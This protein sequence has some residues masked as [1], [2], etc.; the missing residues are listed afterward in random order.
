MRCSCSFS[1]WWRRSLASYILSPSSPRCLRVVCWNMFERD[2][3]A[4]LLRAS[5]GDAAV[6]L[7]TFGITLFRG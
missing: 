3:F 4:T 5:R 1:F 6:L 7:A 2:A